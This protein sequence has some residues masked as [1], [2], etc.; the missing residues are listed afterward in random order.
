MMV[1]KTE[2]QAKR[3]NRLYHS[4]DTALYAVH[5]GLCTTHALVHREIKPFQGRR[6]QLY[7][8]HM[9]LETD[10]MIQASKQAISHSS[11]LLSAL[12]TS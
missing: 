7:Y 8:F 11:F 1:S 4:L 6:E 3:A 9:Y 5:S 2:T 12:I 10:V